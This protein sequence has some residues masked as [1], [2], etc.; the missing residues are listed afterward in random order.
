MG[1]SFLMRDIIHTCL[2]PSNMHTHT[3]SCLNCSAW[4]QCYLSEMFF[5]PDKKEYV[6][7]RCSIF[8][9]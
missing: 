9:L 7:M 3:D 1:F 4:S 6:A 8:N 5:S 2:Y